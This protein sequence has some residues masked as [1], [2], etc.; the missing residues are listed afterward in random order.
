MGLSSTFV[1][2]TPRPHSTLWGPATGIRGLLCAVTCCVLRRQDTQEDYEQ[3]VVP[4][5]QKYP[6][7]RE[8]PNQYMLLYIPH[9]AGTCGA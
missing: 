4:L 2:S 9:H 7:V 6:E 5:L 8:H 1:G 3:H